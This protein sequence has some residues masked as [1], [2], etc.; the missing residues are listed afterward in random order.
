[1]PSCS[2]EGSLA[3]KTN[4]APSCM[5]YRLCESG[6]ASQTTKAKYIDTG[7]APLREDSQNMPSCSFSG[8]L[9]PKANTALS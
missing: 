5:H 1:M 7:S 4:A 2:L 6:W 9:A 3:R 8:S